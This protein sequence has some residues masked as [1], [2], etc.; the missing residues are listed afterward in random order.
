[1]FPSETD[2]HVHGLADWVEPFWMTQSQLTGEPCETVASSDW[3]VKRLT[4]PDVKF[5]TFVRGFVNEI[6]WLP[7]FAETPYVFSD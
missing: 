1:M 6:G 5:F 3:P 7:T 4:T 2:D